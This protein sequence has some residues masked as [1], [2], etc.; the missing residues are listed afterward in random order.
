MHYIEELLRFKEAG[1]W[2][3]LIAAAIIGLRYLAKYLEEHKE[4]SERTKDFDKRLLEVMQKKR[5]EQFDKEMEKKLGAEKYR[6]MKA[7]FDEAVEKVRKEN[8]K[9]DGDKF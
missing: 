5:N 8:K 2:A 7:A 3:F 6:E 1:L 4:S 9:K